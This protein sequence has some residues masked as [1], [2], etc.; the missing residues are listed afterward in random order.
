MLT[1]DKELGLKISATKHAFSASLLPYSTMM[2]E[3]A[4]HQDELEVVELKLNAKEEEQLARSVQYIK[5]HV[6]QLGKD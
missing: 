3:E 2:L 1:A 5:D 6:A 4:L